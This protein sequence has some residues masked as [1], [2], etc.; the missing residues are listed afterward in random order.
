MNFI[1]TMPRPLSKVPDQNKPLHSSTLEMHSRLENFANKIAE[2]KD[3]LVLVNCM[4]VNCLLVNCMLVNCLLV[5][6]LL[7]NCRVCKLYVSKLFVSKLY[8]S[9]LY[10][11]KLYV[12]CLYF[13]NNFLLTKCSSLLNAD[14]HIFTEMMNIS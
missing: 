6:C 4:L 1:S 13:T 2:N 10:V 7:V 14:L 9:K 3:D 11:S 12:S 5:N 8:I